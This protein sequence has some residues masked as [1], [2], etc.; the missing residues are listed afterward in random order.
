MLLAGSFG[1]AAGM[2]FCRDWRGKI[3]LALIGL[4]VGWLGRSFGVITT[5]IGGL[6]PTII[7]VYIFTGLFIVYGALKS[8]RVSGGISAVVYLAAPLLCL[9][10]FTTPDSYQA[11][12]YALEASRPFHW[13]CHYL[14][15]SLSLSL[16]SSDLE[17]A[18][19]FLAFA[20]TYHYLNWFSKTRVINWHNISRRRLTL[21]FGIYILAVS[22]YAI[23]YEL[24]FV[25]LL[26]LS[27]GHVYLEFPL[28][29]RS[30][31]GIVSELRS[32]ARNGR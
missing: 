15:R 16:D 26:A 19:R 28:N 10:V 13:L 1:A 2:A 4:A 29:F 11:S 27:A 20:Y 25:V 8:R 31:L 32:I 17:V 14:N 22:A 21:I 23:S 7:H 6:L 18:M 9:Y 24:G 5:L 30:A 12:R 3:T